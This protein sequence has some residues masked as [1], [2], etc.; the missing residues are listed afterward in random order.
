LHWRLFLAILINVIEGKPFWWSTSINGKTTAQ[1]GPP[2]EW[3]NSP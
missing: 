2:N 3:I 1:P